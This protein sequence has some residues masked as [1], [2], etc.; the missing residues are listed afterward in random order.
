MTTMGPAPTPAANYF[1]NTGEKTPI[2]EGAGIFHD[3]TE[4]VKG[5]SSGNWAVGLINAGATVAGGG[6]RSRRSVGGTVQ[7]GVRVAGRARLVSEGAT[8]LAHR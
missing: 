7:R 1:V 8:G 6:K 5:S 3:A 4:T 2:T